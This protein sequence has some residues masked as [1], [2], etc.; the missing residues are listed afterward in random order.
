MSRKRIIPEDFNESVLGINP[1][2]V[3]LE[4]PVRFVNRKRKMYSVDENSADVISAGGELNTSYMIE[5]YN[6]IKLFCSKESRAITLGLSYRALQMMLWIGYRLNSAKDY[7]VINKDEFMKEVDVSRPTMTAAL[8]EL[9]RKQVIGVT[10]YENIFWINPSV[11]YKGSRM[12][13][14]PSKTVIKRMTNE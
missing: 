3:K 13:K 6:P 14:F 11:F 2:S 5:S 12:V 8:T 10:M 9:V 1:L 7:A 4:I